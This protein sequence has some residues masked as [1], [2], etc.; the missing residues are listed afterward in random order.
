MLIQN[1]ALYEDQY[2]I[3]VNHENDSLFYFFDYDVRSAEFN[4]QFQH[5]HTF[6]E[7][8]VMLEPN[9]KHFLEGTANIYGKVFESMM[10]KGL[11]KKGDP[12]ML[13]FSF[14][15]PI[16][17]LVHLCDREPDRQE[18]AMEKIKGIGPAKAKALTEHFK[19]FADLKK[20][21]VAELAEVNGI[22]MKDAEAVYEYFNTKKSN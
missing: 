12:A 7:L 11:M 4:M 2:F 13:A 19:S 18:E 22:S 3:R 20:A 21:S 8:C 9:T 1:L 10:E 5:F 16:S 14:T 17:A 15:A 6:Y